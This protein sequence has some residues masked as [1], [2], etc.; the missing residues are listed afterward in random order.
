MAKESISFKV[1]DEV[2]D[3]LKSALSTIQRD[4]GFST[5]EECLE[6]L[7]PSIEAEC[8]KEV[9]PSVASHISAINSAL[10]AIAAQTSSMASAAKLSEK[11]V[12]EESKAQIDALSAALAEKQKE[13]ARAIAERDEA[14]AYASELKARIQ[15]LETSLARRETELAEVRKQ[16]L[17]NA[18]SAEFIAKAL[19]SMNAL[20][21]AV[22]SAGITLPDLA[23]PT[24]DNPFAAMALKETPEP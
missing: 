3:R 22:G 20:T 14:T 12:R 2:R 17:R 24:A 19:A 1:G 10:S 4:R 18:D 23:T 5:Q 6:A 11:A 21:E 15:D 16:A 13:A 7:L 9:T 8:A